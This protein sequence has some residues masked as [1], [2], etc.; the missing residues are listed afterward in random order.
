M[1]APGP[2]R[3]TRPRETGWR[4]RPPER[5]R[6]SVIILRWR[7]AAAPRRRPGCGEAWRHLVEA[8]VPLRIAPAAFRNRRH[9]AA[10]GTMHRPGDVAQRR[11][12]QIGITMPCPDGDRAEPAG[13]HVV[14]DGELS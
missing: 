11:D 1:A 3:P 10:T 4:Q 9:G 14:D 13:D 8:A 7:C 2:G 5:L 6:A 12:D